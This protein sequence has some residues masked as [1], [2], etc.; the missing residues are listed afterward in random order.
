MGAGMGRLSRVTVEM[1]GGGLVKV[2]W[3]LRDWLLADLEAVDGA[4]S[5][6]D[7]FRA[8]GATRPVVLDERERVW[9]AGFLDGL[10]RRADLPKGLEPLRA[11]LH[12]WRETALE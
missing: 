7:A 11:G 6:V 8:V 3:G 5:I 9:L 4:E 1:F 12:P 10:E 2:P